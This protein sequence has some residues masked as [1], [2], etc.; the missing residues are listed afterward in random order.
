M[1]KRTIKK[2][3]L[4]QRIISNLE[5][6]TLKGGVTCEAPCQGG[7]GC[8]NTGTRNV[9]CNTDRTICGGEDC[10]GKIDL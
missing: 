9:Y 5:C 1:K 6:H 7:T 8:C 2:L 10:K 4:R 3:V